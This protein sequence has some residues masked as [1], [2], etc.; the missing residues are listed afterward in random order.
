MDHCSSSAV[1]VVRRARSAPGHPGAPVSDLLLIAAD[2]VAITLLTFGSFYRR[3]GRRDMLLAYVGLNVGVL[4]VATVLT[5]STVSAGLGLG[6][7]GVL[8]IIRLR[9]SE[10]SQEE[11]AYYFASLALGLIFGLAPEP[12]WIAPVLG[13][14]IVG[15]V[16]LIDHMPLHARSRHQVVTLDR[17]L[18]DE[19]DLTDHLETLL[20]GTVRRAVVLSTDLVRDSMVIDVRY[21]LPDTART[22]SAGVESPERPSA[23]HAP[24]AVPEASRLHAMAI[25]PRTEPGRPDARPGTRPR[26]DDAAG[27]TA[28]TR[29]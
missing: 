17:V 14:L 7:F 16:F 22:P 29:R 25:P 27:L 8:S 28:G 9:S 1:H 10:I 23:A 2:L 26:Q 13:A 20:G 11:V 6:L 15:V 4:A 5:G 24:A 19:A 18:T 21:E 3:H 12:L